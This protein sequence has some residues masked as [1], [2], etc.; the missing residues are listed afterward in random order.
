MKKHSLFITAV[1]LAALF[2]GCSFHKNV[3]ET[4]SFSNKSVILPADT[5]TKTLPLTGF[6]TTKDLWSKYQTEVTLQRTENGLNIQ[7]LCYWNQD[8]ALWTEKKPD[9]NIIRAAFD[10]HV[11]GEIK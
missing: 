1:I 2:S 3:P 6:I 9:D 8:N 11:E 7:F 10:N 5:G 4:F